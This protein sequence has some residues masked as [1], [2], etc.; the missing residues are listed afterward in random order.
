M[1]F[2]YGVPTPF[3]PGPGSE[4]HVPRYEAGA[5]LGIQSSPPKIRGRSDESMAD[6]VMQVAD[7]L[8]HIEKEPP[9]GEIES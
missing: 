3:N 5:K 8:S 9:Y 2:D 1:L 4:F 7:I 6:A